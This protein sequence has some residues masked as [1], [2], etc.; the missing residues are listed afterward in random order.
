MKT[1]V[2]G[3]AARVSSARLLSGN[4]AVAAGA[5]AAGVA[6][7]TGYPG[8]PCTEVHES[9]RALSRTESDLSVSWS[10]N[11]KVA[12]EIAIGASLAGARS[13]SV[14]KTLGLNVA[15]DAFTQMT[16]TRLAAGLVLVVAD[17]VG[18]VLGDD[19][20]DCR[21]YAAMTGAPVLEP[22]NPSEC[23]A[24]TMEAFEI[25]EAFSTPV[26]VRLTSVTC[27]TS[28]PVEIPAARIPRRV[29]EVGFSGTRTITNLVRHGL[30]GL[31][32]DVV[33]Q[34]VFDEETMLGS[35][36]E[37]VNA[38][39]YN[40]AEPGQGRVGLIATGIAA[41]YAREAFPDLPMLKLGISWPL[42]IRKAREFSKG[43][44]AVVVLEDGHPVV[45]RGLRA[46]NLDVRGR[47]LVERHPAHPC[48]SPEVIRDALVKAFADLEG[49][50]P[51]LQSPG[52]PLPATAPRLTSNCSGCPHL[53]VFRVLRELEVAVAAGIGCCAIGSSPHV[54]V[55]D[56][57][58]CMGAP[59]G[60]AAGWQLAG[61]RPIVALIGDGE[62]WHTG[63][64]GLID[65]V[66][67][68]NPITMI[69][70]ENE[71]VA[72]TGGQPHPSSPARRG[73]TRLSIAGIV[74]AL[75]VDDVKVVDT[76]DLAALRI[77]V[78]DAVAE[79]RLSVV[80]AR[81]PCPTRLKGLNNERAALDADA[82]SQCRDCL[83]LGCPSITV[84]EGRPSLVGESC[85][86]CGL[87]V[88][89]CPSGAIGW[90]R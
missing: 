68:E 21:E 9:L 87:C 36:Q 39:A 72:M 37:L 11:E 51:L 85:V 76:Y 64:M 34:L 80:V 60:V 23:V 70:V 69:I 53:F 83:T 78:A 41:S 86:G 73:G 42:P 65:A 81:T 10:V 5:W 8:A 12:L 6:V 38:S 62:F 33:S 25:S 22:A 3:A 57:L 71:V 18:R 46:A 75:G 17:D 19:D 45:E 26:I 20:Q 63:I 84:R 31:D 30:V 58:K 66:A 55:V 61:G 32:R 49:S 82:C 29:P 47:D 13:L 35:L 48:L 79:P 77:A 56:I 52:T 40:V 1:S 24:F 44:D 89:T 67:T 16:G 54:G 74:A 50:T 7:V 27:R 43:L 4:A 28:S 90:C 15:A 14:M 59:P 88:V 2:D